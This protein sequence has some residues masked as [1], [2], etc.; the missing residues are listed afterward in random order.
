MPRYTHLVVIVR[1]P[2]MEITVRGFYDR[3][4][5]EHFADEVGTQWS[6][7]YVTEILRGPK[8]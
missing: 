2:G 6:E 7:T 4:E 3:A 1:E 5:A 8:T